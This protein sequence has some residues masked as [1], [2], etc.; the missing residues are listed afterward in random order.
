MRKTKGMNRF[1]KAAC[2]P[3]EVRV[4]GPEI[5]QLLEDSRS[6]QVEKRIQAA[7]FL[8]P[9]HVR[10]RIDEVWAALFRMLE[11]DDVRVRRAAWHTLDDGGRPDDP[12]LDEIITR[13]L[14]RETD[15]QV[16]GFAR[17]FSTSRQERQR[18]MD[19]VATLP[20]FRKRGK[21][22]FCGQLN[23]PVTEKLDVPIESSDG[24]TRAALI[25]R[26]RQDE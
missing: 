19:H 24:T 7:E 16:L 15:S 13:T 18:M 6:R 20:S 23:L 14:S 17:Q 4:S 8:C 9:C 5:A 2:R 10:R 22:D 11:D 21:C 3:G 1:Q 12:A 25:C 26:D